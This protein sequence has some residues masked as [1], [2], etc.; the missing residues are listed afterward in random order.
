[1]FS[2]EKQNEKDYE[3]FYHDYEPDIIITSIRDYGYADL[4]AAEDG[5][6]FYPRPKDST[7]FYRIDLNNDSI[8]DFR[9]EHFHRF[10]NDV[11]YGCG[12]SPH[13]FCTCWEYSHK[14]VALDS[15][16]SVFGNPNNRGFI[17]FYQ[18]G[19][20]IYSHL[21][22]SD[23]RYI[24]LDVTLRCS[25]CYLLTNGVFYIGFKISSNQKNIIGWMQ[26]NVNS[27]SLLIKDYAYIN[28]KNNF[29]IAGQRE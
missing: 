4:N 6:C 26:I 21:V 1:M 18:G 28:E 15:N 2:C 14:I 13:W 10:N 3:I 19:D 24:Y 16:S 20:T 25:G 8:L 9:F 5:P 17:K 29:I 7:A 23:W 11:V 22:T 12:G 27:D